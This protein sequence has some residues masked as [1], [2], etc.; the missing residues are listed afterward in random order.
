MLTLADFDL[1]PSLAEL[2]LVAA[3]VGP[4]EDREFARL[5]ATT[6]EKARGA[7]A[8][9]QF[10]APA[11]CI[12]AMLSDGSFPKA[13]DAPGRTRLRCVAIARLALH[14]FRVSDSLPPSVLA[15]YPDF[16]RR[17][18]KFLT[19]GA[20]EAYDEEY[21]AKDVRY[22]LGVTAPAGALQFDFNYHISPK[23]IL[24][25]ALEAKDWRP[26]VAYIASAGWGRWYSEHIDLRAMRDFNPDGWTAHCV[27]MAEV[28]AL[29]PGV[30]GIVG[31]GWFYDPAVSENSPGLAY[32]RRTQLRHGGFLVRIGT[33]PHH[34][35]NA[36][37]RS[38][39][40]R[41]LYEEG[42]YLPTCYMLAWPKASLMA[43][44]KRL[45]I[46]PGL[47]FAA[48]DSALPAQPVLAVKQA[49]D[50]QARAVAR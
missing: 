29:N 45:S 26:L 30:R 38:A 16:F 8:Y 36:I 14:H 6:A 12:D 24:R 20:G 49:N 33:E 44:A 43:W 27:R 50:S 17:M 22:A 39:V 9:W 5:L 10:L 19:E 32:I 7:A 40:R 23:L 4:E 31:V 41:R 25:H 42:K 18:A 47:G 2:E 11:Q 48:S 28:L 3:N 34:I 37:Y 13:V 46:D 35:Q 21:F 15:L 1:G